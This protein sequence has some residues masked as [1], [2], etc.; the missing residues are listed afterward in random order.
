M[1]GQKMNIFKV[2]EQQNLKYQW[3]LAK[4][5]IDEWLTSGLF[6]YKWWI[7]LILFCI[8]AILL[9][10]RADKSRIVELTI[11]TA[12]VVLFIIVLDELGEE[13]TLWYYPVDIIPLFPPITAVN[14]TCMPL[15]YML[16]YQRFGMWGKFLIV[17]LIMSI[18]F[19]FVLEPVFVWGGIYTMLKW[20]YYYGFP[21]YIAIAVAAKMI[22]NVI[23]STKEKRNS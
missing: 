8:S 19:C 11:Y 4:A 2:P 10:K 20:K 3:E 7:L 15:V 22:V 23:Y 17:T 1:E 9:W 6:H 21:I 5:R 14:I 12:I 16:I 13:L 18:V